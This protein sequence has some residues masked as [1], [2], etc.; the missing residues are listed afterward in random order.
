[1]REN[2]EDI[3]IRRAIDTI[4]ITSKDA[5]KLAPLLG[6]A[7]LTWLQLGVAARIEPAERLSQL[8][9]EVDP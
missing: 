7:R 5:V 1:M 2:G 3:A 9:L 8:L 4:L 6:E